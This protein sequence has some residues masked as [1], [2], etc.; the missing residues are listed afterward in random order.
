MVDALDAERSAAK[1][2]KSRDDDAFTCDPGTDQPTSELRERG[3][4]PSE[5]PTP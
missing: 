4:R 5:E 2:R 1:K 3:P